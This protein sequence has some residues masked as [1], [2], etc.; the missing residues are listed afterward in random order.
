M[1]SVMI[2][3]EDNPFDYFNN[4]EDWYNFDIQKG[5]GTCSLLARIARTS[6]QLSDEQNDEEIERAIDE[7]MKLDV[8]IDRNGNV[9]KYK[10]ISEKDFKQ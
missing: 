6:D 3:T 4:F 2:T 8:A 9:V 7:I 10:K 1:G 5:Y